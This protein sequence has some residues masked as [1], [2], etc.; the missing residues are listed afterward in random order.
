MLRPF[1]QVQD[2]FGKA[3]GE[4]I[5]PGERRVFEQPLSALPIVKL[6]IDFKELVC[7]SRPLFSS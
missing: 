7:R 1:G 5:E 3:C 6:R 2:W 4:K